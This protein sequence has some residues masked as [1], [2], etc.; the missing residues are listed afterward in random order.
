ML[1]EITMAPTQRTTWSAIAL[2]ILATMF[3]MKAMV[4]SDA[5]EQDTTPRRLFLNCRPPDQC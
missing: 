2:K 1:A 4:T 5:S 3:A